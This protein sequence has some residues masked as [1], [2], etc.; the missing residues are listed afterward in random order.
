MAL[1]YIITTG[2]SEKFKDFFEIL[3]EQSVEYRSDTMTI[4]QRLKNEG[5]EEGMHEAARNLLAMGV[6]RNIVI[7]ATK[8]SSSDFEKL[9]H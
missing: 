5:F 8:I 2:D 4:A 6:D 7:Q 1:E 9:Q 3:A